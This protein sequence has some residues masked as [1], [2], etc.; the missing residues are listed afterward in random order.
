MGSLLMVSA[1]C[2]AMLRV[3]A[4][5]CSSSK[6]VPTWTQWGSETVQAGFHFYSPLTPNRTPTDPKPTAN[7]PTIASTQFHCLCGCQTEL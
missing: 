5:V 3:M 2:H 4:W 6:G 7:Q 1:Q